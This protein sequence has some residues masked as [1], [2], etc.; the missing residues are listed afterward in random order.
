MRA[1]VAAGLVIF[2]SAVLFA[3][4][5]SWFVRD[6]QAGAGS[7]VFLLWGSL[8]GTPLLFVVSGMGVRY[9]MRTRSAG[10]F[11]RERPARLLVPLTAGLVMPAPPVF[12]LARLGQPGFR[13]PYWRLGPWIGIRARKQVRTAA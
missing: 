13:E 12:Y 9:A 8:R 4:D 11:A 2:H 10:R 6:P 3:A 1:F 7:A 5:S